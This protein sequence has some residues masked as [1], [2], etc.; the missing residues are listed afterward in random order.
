M[1][2]LLDAGADVKLRRTSGQT[3][4]LEHDDPNSVGAAAEPS[5]SCLAADALMIGAATAARNS[6]HAIGRAT[7]MRR[8]IVSH[9]ARPL[10]LTGLVGGG[11]CI[12]CRKTLS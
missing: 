3:A 5:P 1:R 7:N 12:H 9:R 8:R 2:A 10:D 11:R 6:T 4:V